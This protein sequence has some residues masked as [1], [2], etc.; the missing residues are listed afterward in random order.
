MKAVNTTSY[1]PGR[2]ASLDVFRGITIALMIVVNN[3]GGDVS[4]PALQH[5][6][7]NGWTLADLVFPFFLFIVGVAIPFSLGNRIARGE[8]RRKVLLR[9]IRR[10]VVLFAL[11][12]FLNGF[13]YFDLSTLRIMGVLQ[14]IALCYF[15][16]S[17][18]FLAFNVRKQAM[19]AVLISLFYWAIMTLVPVPGYG[20][21]VLGKQGNLASYIDNLLLG[22]QHLWEGSRAWGDPEGLLSTIPAVATTLLGVLAGKHLKSSRSSLEKAAYFFFL[23]SVG[24]V[25]GLL[26]GMWFPINKSLWTSSYVAFTGGISFIFLATCYYVIDIKKHMTWTKPFIILGMNAI[27]IYVLSEIVSS[28]VY[29]RVTLDGTAIAL[30]T[31]VYRNY[32]ASWTGSLNG[33]LLYALA[34][35][36]LWI[37]VAAI[38]YKSRIFIKV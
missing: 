35:L 36:V 2:L 31:F 37:A 18:I 16:A 25:V 30:K 33:S 20:A 32:F 27:I 19:I 21:G 26:C 28:A 9:V 11:G 12:L 3:P 22:R 34:Y 29:A 24:I 8:S 1:L 17:L 5:A 7:W 13:P 38:L 15:F 10:S 14:R 6:D 23:G 4:Y